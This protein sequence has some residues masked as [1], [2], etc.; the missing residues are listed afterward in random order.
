M[1]R[2]AQ[3]EFLILS[4]IGNSTLKNLH[5]IEYFTVKQY[6]GLFYVIFKSVS[7]REFLEYQLFQ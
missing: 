2:M 4:K 7:Y 1:P 5:A 6:W 3:T